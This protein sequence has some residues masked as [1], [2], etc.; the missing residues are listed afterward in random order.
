MLKYLSKRKTDEAIFLRNTWCGKIQCQM[1]SPHRSGKNK[2]PEGQ[3]NVKAQ[4]RDLRTSQGKPRLDH[5]GGVVFLLLF[6]TLCVW[7]CVPMCVFLKHSICIE[8]YTHLLSVPLNKL[9]QNEH[10]YT[11][12]TQ[13][14]GSNS[15]STS[16]APPL[17]LL[18]DIGPLQLTSDNHILISNATD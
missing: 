9:S 13:A 3:F 16:E 12:A 11:S 6:K 2:I 10:I 15:I 17:G 14:K 18:P 7:V 1:S 8:K 5:T 4:R